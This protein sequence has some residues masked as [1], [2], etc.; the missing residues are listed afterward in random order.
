VQLT[1]DQGGGALQ[2]LDGYIALGLEDTIKL[3]A[4]GMHPRGQ[5]R[6]A[7]ALPFYLLGEL[8][9]HHAQDGGCLCRL[10]D[11]FLLQEII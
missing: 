1:P 10:L 9:C 8:L 5:F 4:I 2:G 6:L 7:K 11:T 3:R